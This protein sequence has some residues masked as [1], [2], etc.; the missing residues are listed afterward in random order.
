MHPHKPG[1]KGQYT[2]SHHDVKCRISAL[3]TESDITMMSLHVFV[4]S[5]G[6]DFLSPI[7]VWED[8]CSAPPLPGFSSAWMEGNREHFTG[9]EAML[10]NTV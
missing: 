10:R 8:A 4:Q 3:M 1:M 7:K 9:K 5:D 6:G 2:Y